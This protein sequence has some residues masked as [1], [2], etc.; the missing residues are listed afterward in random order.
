MVGVAV[1]AFVSLAMLALLAGLVIWALAAA[2]GGQAPTVIVGVVVV[3]GTA[4]VGR[5]VLR[6]LRGS[7]ASVGDLLDGAAQQEIG[8]AHV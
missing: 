1:F 3:L 5:A 4:L 7:A 6:G 8:R 2:F